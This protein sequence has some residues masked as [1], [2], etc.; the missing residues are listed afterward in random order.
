MIIM[1]MKALFDPR[2]VFITQL[3]A[4]AFMTGV[5]WLV[6]LIL[7]PAFSSI[8]PDRFADFHSLH[9]RRITWIVAPAMLLEAASAAWLTY[10]E[11][12]NAL[13]IW[14][15][16][17]VILVWVFT[18]IWSVPI[19]GQLAIYQDHSNI[20]RLVQTNWPRTI[21]WTTRL[22]FLVLIKP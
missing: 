17:T 4:C 2:L 6:Q 13:M 7:Y 21:V 8:S 16:V 15:L 10:L 12:A 22:I 3:I 1:I 5:I 20:S 9:M 19:H 14:S 11:P 18:A